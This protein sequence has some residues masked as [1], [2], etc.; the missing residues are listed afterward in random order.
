MSKA[1][2]NLN[3]VARVAPLV[4]PKLREVNHYF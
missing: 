3:N 2:Y 4:I 1:G